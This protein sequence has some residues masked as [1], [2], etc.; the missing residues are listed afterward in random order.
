MIN[1]KEEISSLVSVA[2]VD[3]RFS[4][5]DAL[6]IVWH[7]HY[8]TYFEDGREAFGRQYGISYLDIQKNGYSRPIVKTSTEHFLP[9]KYGET[10]R[11][12]TNFINVSAAKMVFRY[13]IFNESNQLVC[14]GETVQV[15][16]D[17]EGNLSYYNPSFFQEWKE[18]WGLNKVIGNEA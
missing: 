14:T 11:I 9:L 15:F 13:K 17:G 1:K 5:V 4:E 2:F 18:K 3:V 8:I 10:F 6:G 12:E 16:V 7:G